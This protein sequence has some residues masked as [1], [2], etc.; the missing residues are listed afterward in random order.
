[1]QA[2]IDKAVSYPTRLAVAGIFVDDSGIPIKGFDGCEV[3]AMLGHISRSFGIIPF[4]HNFIVRTVL[5][6]ASLFVQDTVRRLPELGG[7]LYLRIAR[8]CTNRPCRLV[9]AHRG[10][11]IGCI[12][13]WESSSVIA[14]SHT[15]PLD[16]LSSQTKCNTLLRCCHG[17]PI[18]TD[19]H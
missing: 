13:W 8:Y 6:V 9:P 4:K 15:S 11:K 1:M 3:D 14:T 12:G 10:M 16:S 18:Q 17:I 19:L 5:R 2:V 7:C